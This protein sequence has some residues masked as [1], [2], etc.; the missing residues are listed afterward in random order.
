MFI[1]CRTL[2]CKKNVIQYIY[3]I[4]VSLGKILFCQF[5]LCILFI[6]LPCQCFELALSEQNWGQYP[7]FTIS[8]FSS[9]KVVLR[10]NKPKSTA[11]GL[12][13][14]LTRFVD[15]KNMHVFLFNKRITES[16]RPPDGCTFFVFWRRREI[17]NGFSFK[18][19]NSKTANVSKNEVLHIRKKVF[20]T[21]FIFKKTR[22]IKFFRVFF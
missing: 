19:F 13:V 17:H 9:A 7:T 12:C 6:Q 18:Q 16:I 10:V 20:W 1:F 14:Q 11:R 3:I 22:Q 15:K 2:F 4:F 5:T 8:M 21:F